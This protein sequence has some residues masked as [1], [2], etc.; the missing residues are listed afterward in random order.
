MNIYTRI[1]DNLVAA[2]SNLKE[3]WENSTNVLQRHR[4]LPGHQGGKYVEDNCTYLTL[5]EH[6]IAHYLLWK[7]HR[8]PGDYRA[9]KM[10]SGIDVPFSEH[11][12]YTKK[13]LSESHKGIPLSAEHRRKI[14]EG[15]MGRMP[16][17]GGKKHSEE[18]RRKMSESQKGRE[19]TK[20]HRE[21]LSNSRKKLNGSWV[22][23]EYRKNMANIVRGRKHTEE[24]KRKMR[25]AHI[26][27]RA[28][29]KQDLNAKN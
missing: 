11:S 28:A 26:K 6:I 23:E 2:S 25:E 19:I 12:E 16:G 29:K 13:R 17:F 10:M 1:Y 24:T 20:K 5:R 8:N 15:Q 3:E 14:S 21:N 18:T 27:R 9:Y 22:T 7:I 4:I